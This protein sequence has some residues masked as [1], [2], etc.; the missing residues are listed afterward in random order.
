[1]KPVILQFKN[2]KKTAAYGLLKDAMIYEYVSVEGKGRYNNFVFLRRMVDAG[3]LE[4]GA[5]GP[6]GGTHYKITEKGRATYAELQ[7]L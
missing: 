6:R 3:L 5:F 2:G 1:M 4:A 7:I